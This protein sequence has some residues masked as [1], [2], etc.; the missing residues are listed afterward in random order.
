M[1]TH[2]ITR[3]GLVM[4]LMLMTLVACAKVELTN[5]AQHVEKIAAEI[6]DFTLL[7]GYEPELTAQALGYSLASY[8]GASGP[9][10][11]YLIQSEKESDNEKLSQMLDK[12][13]PGTRDSNARMTVVENRPAS[14]RGQDV[15]LVISEGV[16][17][18]KVSYRQISV[19]FAGKGGPALLV[20]SETTGNWDQAAIDDFLASFR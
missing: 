18:E 20:I 15:T 16:N 14:V 2:K 10:H 7:P 11:L 1:N 12:L 13:S 3:I 6:A 5:D 9:S 4:V 8:K 17:S 19:G